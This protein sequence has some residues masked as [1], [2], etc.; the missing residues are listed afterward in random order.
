M[1]GART[2]GSDKATSPVSLKHEEIDKSL[3]DLEI[4]VFA[5]ENLKFRIGG[6]E[7]PSPIPTDIE[8]KVTVDP[9]SFISVLNGTSAKVQDQ[10]ARIRSIVNDI[11]DMLF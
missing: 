8:S 2:T 7:A 6:Q 5:L 11:R 1:S 4:A 9:P 3:N 10:T